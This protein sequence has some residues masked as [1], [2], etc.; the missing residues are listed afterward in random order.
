MKKG[1]L[2][3]MSLFAVMLV[4]TAC[5]NNDNNNNAATN[6]PDDGEVYIPEF[7]E[8]LDPN[9]PGWMQTDR[10][11]RVTLRWFVQ[12]E[13]WDT[14]WGE[15]F[16]TR[17]I[18]ELLNID[19]E[20]ITGNEETLNL[21][22]ADGNLPDIITTFDRNS[23]AVL[24]APSWALPLNVLAAEYDPYFFNV[25]SPDTLGWFRLDDG[26]TYGYAN[27]SNTTYD[28]A[29]DLLPAPTS[30]LIRRDVHEAIGEMPM[31]TPEEFLAAMDAI[32]EAFP[33]LVP[34]GGVGGFGYQFQ[35]YIGVPVE[36]ANGN[37]HN[38]NLDEDYLTWMRT[39]AEAHNRGHIED[40]SFVNDWSIMEERIRFGN[41][42]TLFLGSVIHQSG[43]L[44]NWATDNP[45][46]EYIA[47]DGPASTLGRERTLGQA[48]ISGWMINHI[49]RDAHAEAAIQLFTFLLSEQGQLLTFYGVEGETF[50]W[51]E[52]GTIA[53]NA[54]II[55]LRET[56]G[57]AHHSQYRFG[58]FFF[59]GHDSWRRLN[60]DQWQEAIRQPLEWGRGRLVPQF[61]IEAI[62]PEQGS[63]EARS[64]DA[65]NTEWAR[66]QIELVRSSGGADFDAL[67]AEYEAFINNNNWDSIMEIRNANM[68][69]NRERLGL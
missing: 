42:A 37:F 13:W 1:F 40:D 18:E 24:G 10:T 48:G 30:F 4:V 17:T 35:N 69:I 25:A 51:N 19:V 31:E 29:N 5:G 43:N 64:L 12:A 54:D 22:F 46:S 36:D 15:D 50:E 52:D 2:L 27:F 62:D 11:E 59:F 28:Y 49:S 58:E 16:I 68:Q 26:N 9:V 3:L 14:R 21:I 41:Y 34:M 44:Q 45:G 57:S 20:F 66:I 53:M 7:N 38:R 39:F 8:G 33:E 61:V 67:V 65:I 47:I 6:V 63:L 60:P 32:A 23:Q 55:E 56:D